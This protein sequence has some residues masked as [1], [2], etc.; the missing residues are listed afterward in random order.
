MT[1]FCIHFGT[2]FGSGLHLIHVYKTPHAMTSRGMSHRLRLYCWDWLI[3]HH[4]TRI[5]SSFLYL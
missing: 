3:G 5:R 2:N 4:W 1:L